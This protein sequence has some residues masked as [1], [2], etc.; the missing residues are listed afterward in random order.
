MSSVTRKT[1]TLAPCAGNE[2]EL[3]QCFRGGRVSGTWKLHGP[4]WERKET[5]GTHMFLSSLLVAYFSSVV[6]LSSAPA[7]IGMSLSPTVRPLR[8]SGPFCYD[9][10]ST[11]FPRLDQGLDKWDTPYLMRWPVD[12]LTVSSLLPWNYRRPIGGTKGKLGL[13]RL[14]RSFGPPMRDNQDS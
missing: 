10:W 11:K 8:I 6:M 2:G 4:R 9:P 14:N 7:W 1:S 5:W 3:K 13:V 12:D